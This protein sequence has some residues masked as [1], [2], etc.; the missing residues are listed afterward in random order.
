[1]RAGTRCLGLALL[2]A[3][4][5]VALWAVWALRKSGIPEDRSFFRSLREIAEEAVAMVLEGAMA[6]ET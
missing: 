1:M 5:L 3:S 4:P 6:N 2:A